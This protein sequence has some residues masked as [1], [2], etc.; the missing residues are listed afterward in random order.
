MAIELPSVGDSAN[1]GNGEY[2]R[3]ACMMY[4]QNFKDIVAWITG[5]GKE[6]G[7]LNVSLPISQGGTGATTA[8]AART[9]LG[10]VLGPNNELVYGNNSIEMYDDK[11]TLYGRVNNDYSFERTGLGTYSLND[12]GSFSSYGYKIL[13]PKDELDNVLVA[14]EVE[15]VER[16]L[17]VKTYAVK[18]VNGKAVMDTATPMDIPSGRFISLNVNKGL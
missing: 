5:G 10:L 18:Y 11:F 13:L 4:N 9:N 15:I 1:D 2:L 14:A 8:A 12:I 7:V 3:I 16:V 6:S 17:T